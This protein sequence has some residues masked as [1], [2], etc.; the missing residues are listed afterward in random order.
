MASDGQIDYRSEGVCTN[1]HS[2]GQ[3][4]VSTCVDAVQSSVPPTYDPRPL[5]AALLQQLEPIGQIYAMIYDS[6]GKRI[7]SAPKARADE[8]GALQVRPYDSVGHCCAMTFDSSGRGTVSAPV[9][10]LRAIAYNTEAHPF[11]SYE[12]KGQIC[13]MTY[14]SSGLSIVSASREEQETN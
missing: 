6:P 10:T 8:N 13:A 5:D 1:T 3:P 12:P 2:F 14:A 9:E 11:Q 4:W 7:A